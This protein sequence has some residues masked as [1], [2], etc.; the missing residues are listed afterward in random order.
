MTL[1]ATGPTSPKGDPDAAIG[2]RS[3]LAHMGVPDTDRHVDTGQRTSP[4]PK[5]DTKA[6][7]GDDAVCGP[8]GPGTTN[9][10]GQAGMTAERYKARG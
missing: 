10:L 9:T 4:P 2:G 5:V 8:T 1:P 7:D 6:V 3:P